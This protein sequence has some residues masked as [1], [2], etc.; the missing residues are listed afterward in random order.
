MKSIEYYFTRTKYTEGGCWEWQGAL[1]SCGYPVV[2][3]GGNCNVRLQR[4]IYEEINDESLGYD[5]VRHT[6]DNPVCINPEHLVRGSSV[7]NMKDRNERGR[8]H[9]HVTEEERDLVYKLRHRGLKYKEIAEILDV[10]WK[11]VEYIFNSTKW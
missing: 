3:R 8:T 5:V 1:T 10:K 11:R 9:N 4:V 2:S 6:C 7:D